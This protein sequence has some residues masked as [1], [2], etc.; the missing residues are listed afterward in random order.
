M[1]LVKLK[2]CLSPHQK[3]E[4]TND[5]SMHVWF[6]HSRIKKITHTIYKKNNKKN[7]E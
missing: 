6:I 3:L 7:N 1:K 2:G 5:V 4:S